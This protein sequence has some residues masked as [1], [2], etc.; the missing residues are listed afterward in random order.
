MYAAMPRDILITVG[1]EIIEAPMAWRSRYFEWTAYRS[2]M[3][4]YIQAGGKWTLAPKPEM[5]DDLYDQVSVSILRHL[6][7][8]FLSTLA[9]FHSCIMAF[10][11]FPCPFLVKLRVLCAACLEF[12]SR[13][14]QI[15]NS[16]ANSS[17]PLQN[18]RK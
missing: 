14:G 13:I 6:M 2:I 16:V 8:G 18:L 15:L 7:Q 12:K 4:E 10:T 11:S 3:K 17:P 1:D 9:T 5:K